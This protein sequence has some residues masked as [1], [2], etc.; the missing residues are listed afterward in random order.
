MSLVALSESL[1]RPIRA[2]DVV[3][4]H[5]PTDF[6]LV[7]QDVHPSTTAADRNIKQFRDALIEA[8][9]D[10]VQPTLVLYSGRWVAQRDQE[11]WKNT[12]TATVLP[13]YDSARIHVIPE[14]I[15]R[16]VPADYLE[17]LLTR[18]VTLAGQATKEAEG[19]APRLSRYDERWAPSREGLLSL[20]LLCEA[21]VLTEGRPSATCSNIV[22]T[23][24]VEPAQWFAPFR[25]EPT[26]SAVAEIAQLVGDPAASDLLSAVLETT[27]LHAPIGRFL[28]LTQ[29]LEASP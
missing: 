12:I 22:V 8:L 24:P 4:A 20:R 10:G 3:L 16:E 19:V 29:D 11:E 15:D 25:M 28:D 18:A 2:S 9:S 7:S 5:T 23:A 26:R 13:G 27:D 21:W 14:A 17:E 1:S 6:H